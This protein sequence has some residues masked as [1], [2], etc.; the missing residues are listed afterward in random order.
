MRGP[1]EGGGLSLVLRPKWVYERYLPPP[2]DGAVLVPA[3]TAARASVRSR[4]DSASRGAPRVDGRGQ[5]RASVLS[6]SDRL[7]S[8]SDGVPP[9]SR[10]SASGGPASAVV[11]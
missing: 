4:L 1:R 8:T 10:S 6:R 11:I 2:P 5:G 9:V 7:T 3:S